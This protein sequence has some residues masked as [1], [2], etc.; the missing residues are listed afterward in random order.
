MS[1]TK[2]TDVNFWR[3]KCLNDL[4]FLCRVVLQT[5]ESPTPGYKDLYKPTH[6]VMADFVTENAKPEHNV[7]LFC[8]RGW[9]KSYV[10][11]IGF[12]IQKILQN[13][14]SGSGDTI[15]ISNATL[16]NSQMFLK[17]IKYNFEYNELLR[18]LFPEIPREPEKEAKRWTMNEIELGRT[19]VEVGSVEGNLVS[20]HYSILINDDLVNK[21]N[22]STPEQINKVIDWWKLARSL[23]ESKGTEIIIGTRW[24]YDDV[25]GYILQN[26]MGFDVETYKKHREH[27][28]VRVDK[29]N[30]HYLR[31]VCW[32]D[33]INEK[34]STF[35]TLFPE[36][37]L[38][39][40]K[41][42]QG[43]HF[44]T[45]Y[46]NDPIAAGEQIFKQSW[47][48][49]W[50]RGELPD[51]RNTY[52]LV[53][54]SGKDTDSSDR[55][56]MVV[57]SAGC[58]K[59]FY[60]QYARG[61]KKTDLQAVEWMLEIASYYQPIMIGIEENKFE[62]YRDL[63]GY[64]IPQMK[65]MGKI[66]KGSEAYISSCLNIM[67]PLRHRNRPKEIRVKNLTGW[68]EAGNILLPPTGA[69]DLKNELMFF[70]RTRYDDV[71]DALAYILDVGVFPSPNSPPV[72]PLLTSGE[73]FSEEEKKFWENI[74]NRDFGNLLGDEMI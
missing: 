7:L 15:L 73:N 31:L 58:D 1:L 41:R 49:Y 53:D 12:T 54:P 51:V 36:E 40:I 59:R 42:E 16:G 60:V 50:Q 3:E 45:Q 24:H 48:H 38:H 44:N 11:T 13:L 46:L 14:I 2:L 67:F 4:F 33:P 22:C 39:R 43:E 47:V 17:K 56:G 55:T 72:K 10:I 23:L 62:V 20:R 27:P 74:D 9:V 69:T 61:E 70:G 34:G 57:V 5:L 63:A 66:A 35:P 65:K 8:P 68:F 25:Y 19:L 29:D 18:R 21:D 52:L 64:L 26:F 37:K 30:Y 6:K 28:I 32:Q 71:V